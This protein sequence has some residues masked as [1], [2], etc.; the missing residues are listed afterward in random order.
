MNGWFKFHR[1]MLEHPVW[2][3]SPGQTKVWLS[4]L[5]QANHKPVEWWDGQ[6][7]VEIPAGSLITSQPHLAKRAR[8]GRIVV[9]HAL[10]NLEVLGSIRAKVQAKRWTLIEIVNWPTYQGAD[11]GVSQ[12][13]SLRRAKREPS[14][15]HNGRS[16]EGEKKTHSS[17]NDSFHRF[18]TT[19]PRKVGKKAALAEWERLNPNPALVTNILSAIETQKRLPEWQRED[20]RFIPHPRTWLH[21]GR[22]EDEPLDPPSV[23]DEDE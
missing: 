8:V 3:L 9:R 4:C 17:A 22:W 13:V 20:G 7:R 16:K 18:W 11:D 21:Q 2:D 1:A 14:A 19:Y 23:D 5:A 10:S 12:E 6:K 15:S